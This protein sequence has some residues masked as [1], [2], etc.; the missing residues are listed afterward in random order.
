MLQPLCVH[1]TILCICLLLLPRYFCVGSWACTVSSY[2]P[3]GL[4]IGL[5]EV[6]THLVP[7]AFVLVTSLLAMPI[8]LLAVIDP[9][10]FSPFF[11]GFRNPFTF[12]L[13]LVVHMG[14]LAVILVLLAHW[15]FYLFSWAWPI[16]FTFTSCCSHEP[17]SSHSYHVG[18]LGSLPLFLGFHNSFT[19]LLPLVMHKGLLAVILAMLAHRDFYLFSWASTTHLLY[20]Y[21]FYSFHFHL[22]S[23]LGFFYRWTFCPKWVSTLRSLDQKI[24]IPW[25]CAGDF[26]EL[27]RSDKKFGG[28]GVIGEA[29]IKCSYFETQ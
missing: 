15:A 25:L 7:W 28:G 20:S 10:G 19:L 27:I 16:Y 6:P 18:P 5:A 26:N 17:A 21:I 23:L 24:Q 14:L 3:M 12:F 9:L 4:D 11:L 8:D 2:F 13:P 1:S 22:S 29:T